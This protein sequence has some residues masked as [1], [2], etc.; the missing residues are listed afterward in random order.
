MLAGVLA[1]EAIR[2]LFDPPDVEGG[3]VII[4]GALGAGVNIAAAWAL[5]RSERRGLNVE[6]AMAHILDGP[7]RLGRRRSSPA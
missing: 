7:L 4:V 6:G 5:S 1:I 3:L 2:R